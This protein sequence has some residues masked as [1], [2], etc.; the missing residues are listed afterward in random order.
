MTRRAMKRLWAFAPLFIA[1]CSSSHPQIDHVTEA[2]SLPAYGHA[3]AISD[4]VLQALDASNAAN[5][6]RTW[7]VSRDSQLQTDWLMQSPPARYWGQE[8]DRWPEATTCTTS[9]CDPDFQLPRCSTSAD[10]SNNA[11]CTPVQATVKAPGGTPTKLCVGHSDE[12][13]DRFYNVAISAQ[14]W[15]DVTSLT[16]PDG[17]FEAALRN[18]ITYLGKSGRNVTARFLFGDYPVEDVVNSKTLLQALTRDLPAS[19]PLKV[20]VGNY[21]SSDVP[22]SWNHGKMVSADN[23]A[24]IVG[25]ENMW[26][27][28]YLDIMPVHDLSM[29]IAGTSAAEAHRFANA[30]WQWT[31]ANRS[32][33]TWLT[34]SVW[35]NSWSKG[36]V[37]NECAPQYTVPDAGGPGNVTVLSV[38]RLAEIDPSH[39][40]NQSDDALHALAGAAQK[41]LRMSL[42]DL[43]PPTVPEVKLPLGSWPTVLFDKMATL[44]A[45]GGDVYIVVS[46]YGA[47]AGGLPMTEAQYNN[48][49]TVLE[50]AQH[51]R[52][53]IVANPPAGMPSGAALRALLCQHLH[54]APLRFAADGTFDGTVPGN[55]AKLLMADDQA[56]YIGS[57]NQYDANLTE[58]GYIVDDTRAAAELKRDYWDHVW[59]WSSRLAVSGAEASSCQL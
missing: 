56:F 41:T 12:I 48:G 9:S 25:G 39:Q 15:L 58:F 34:W 14:K 1:A 52:D 47:G 17:R 54:I 26:T 8:Y 49:W 43:G 55:H 11:V 27:K 38:G 23:G 2:D 29:Q 30:Q 13:V 51:L 3:S 46:D 32:L 10:C 45:H 21:R 37:G 50:V 57:Q 42:Q 19:A 44:L 28:Q 31:C 35:S 16:P 5:L 22:P 36:S 20:Y 18:A 40:S 7:N 4:A 33:L 24:A 6:G 59:Q 53:Q